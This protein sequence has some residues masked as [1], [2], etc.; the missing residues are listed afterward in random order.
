MAGIH[1]RGH[2]LLLIAGSGMNS[3]P[4]FY[5]FKVSS[6]G[7]IRE[8]PNPITW[9]YALNRL[10][11]AFQDSS[12]VIRNWN[13]VSIKADKLVGGKY[14]AV[15]NLLQLAGPVQDE[16]LLRVN[17]LGF[18]GS[19]FFCM[20]WQVFTLHV[21]VQKNVPT[22]VQVFHASR[23]ICCRLKAL[24]SQ[25]TTSAPRSWCRVSSSK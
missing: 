5:N 2:R 18:K 6:R 22:E 17:S 10:G 16:I 12:E 13:D 7:S 15:K 4:R 9:V 21:N 1:Q 3:Y 11:S 14:L 20:L 23:S 25:T 19:W 8:P 24:R